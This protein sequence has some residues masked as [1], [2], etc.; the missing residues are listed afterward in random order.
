MR[1]TGPQLGLASLK[2]NRQP[3]LVSG[4]K[5]EIAQFRNRRGR[6]ASV[7]LLLPPTPPGSLQFTRQAGLAAAGF[8]NPLLR[9]LTGEQPTTHQDL[10]NAATLT[11]S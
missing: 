10:E 1:I 6:P 5:A 4:N 2:I 3:V 9:G 7:G 8:A 11:R